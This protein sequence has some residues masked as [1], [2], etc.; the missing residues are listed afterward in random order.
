MQLR[1]SVLILCVWATGSTDAASRDRRCDRSLPAPLRWLCTDDTSGE[2]AIDAGDERDRSLLLRVGGPHPQTALFERLGGGRAPLWRARFRLCLDGVYTVQVLLVMVSPRQRQ[3]CAV[4][5]KN[6]SLLLRRHA[7]RHEAGRAPEQCS[8]GLWSW[9]APRYHRDVAQADPALAMADEARTSLERITFAPHPHINTLH[10]RFGAL[11]YN[12]GAPLVLWPDLARRARL[13]LCLVGDSQMRNLANRIIALLDPAGQMCDLLEAQTVHAACKGGP[14]VRYISALFATK[15]FYRAPPIKAVFELD[16]P[17]AELAGAEC[18]AVIVNAGQWAAERGLPVEEHAHDASAA[19]SALARWGAAKRTPVAWM[20]TP[21]YPLNAGQG[22][23]Y[24]A[25]HFARSASG[26]QDGA[27]FRTR[28]SKDQTLCPPRD[29]RFPH[30]L[31]AYNTA[32][33][34]AAAA[35]NVTFLDVWPIIFPLFDLSFDRQ[36]FYDPVSLHVAIHAM[37]W[38]AGVR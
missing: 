36:H 20:A 26:L 15:Q 10:V 12:H 38:A 29:R 3:S 19:M 17:H 18:A 22:D 34:A 8:A 24:R 30:V 27:T 32:V 1:A 7:W 35:A 14:Y 11:Q 25:A 9:R 23:Y 31:H 13:P 6:E 33:A 4:H 2:L 37:R 21:P 5:H 16:Q 28:S